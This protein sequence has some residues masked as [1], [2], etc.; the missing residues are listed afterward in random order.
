MDQQRR[1]GLLNKPN[2]LQDVNSRPLHTVIR[3]QQVLSIF[4][5]THDD[6]CVQLS[7][8]QSLHSNIRLLSPLQVLDPGHPRPLHRLHKGWSSLRSHEY[9]L[10]SLHLCSPSAGP[11]A[12][13][14]LAKGKGFDLFHP[15][16][17]SHVCLNYPL[18]GFF[19]P[20]INRT[21]LTRPHPEHVPWPSSDTSTSSTKTQPTPSTLSGGKSNSPS[22]L[23]QLSLK[24]RSLI[25]LLISQHLRNQHRRHLQLHALIPTP[26]RLPPTQTR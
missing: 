23:P 14:T 11:L 8:R 6:V 24:N 4:D 5:S 22:P 3:H 18:A 13:E 15:D 2:G 9:R 10:R 7:L 12:L 26:F 21:M 17:R 19:S 20:Q 16:E 1:H 25:F